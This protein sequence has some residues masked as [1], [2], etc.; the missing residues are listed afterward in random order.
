[1]G[2]QTGGT[3]QIVSISSHGRLNDAPFEAVGSGVGEPVSGRWD[4]EVTFLQ[5]PTQVDR[6]VALIGILILPTVIFGREQEATR[7]LSS[8][9]DG[10]V[11]FTQISRGNGVV[12]NSSGSVRRREDGGLD[13]HSEAYGNVEL[14][15]VIE[16]E[17]FDAIMLPMGSGKLVDV[18]TFPLVTQEGRRLVHAI[19]DI[20]FSPKT[21][22]PG[23]QFRR[24]HIR[25][26]SSVTTVKIQTSSTIHAESG[27]I[28]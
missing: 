5:S 25:P 16:V 19:R 3:E 27:S 12:V 15:D 11:E 23:V 4:F 1:M 20:T 13:W 21:K 17:P 28:P 6:F 7:N 22:L 10:N 9:A 24:I 14:H 18:L 2:I 26:T 8:L